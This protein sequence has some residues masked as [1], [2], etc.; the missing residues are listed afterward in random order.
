MLPNRSLNYGNRGDQMHLIA[1]QS[2]LHLG[3]LIT[4]CDCKFLHLDWGNSLA[5]IVDWIAMSF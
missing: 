5:H 4:V 3:D 2:T 1:H